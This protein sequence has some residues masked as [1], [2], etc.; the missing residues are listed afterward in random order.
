MAS[1]T[2]TGVTLLYVFRRE[3][4]LN[5][6][7]LIPLAAGTVIRGI[8]FNGLDKLFIPSKTPRVYQKLKQINAECLAKY[9]TRN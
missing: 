3:S 5:L 7:L 8:L 4:I 6:E 9:H 1:M 2:V